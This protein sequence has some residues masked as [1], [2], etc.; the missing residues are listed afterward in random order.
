[1][2]HCRW[3]LL[4][5]IPEEILTGNPDFPPLILQLLY[6]R[7]L[8]EPSRWHSFIAGDESQF[9]DPFLLLGMPAAVNRVYR[10]LLSGE[11]IAIY[12]DFDADGISATALLVQGLSHL[13]YQA[14][15]YIPHRLM[16]GYGLK[17][18]ALEKL[19]QQGI[20]LVIT[21]DCGIT[22]L[23]EIRAA[24][25]MGLDIVVTDHH[26]PLPEIPPAAAIINPRLPGSAYPFRELAG[27]GVALKL[28][29][30]LFQNLGREE[31]LEELM[32]LA[33]LGT[34]ADISPLLGEN[35]YLVKTGL[36]RINNSPRAGIS[37]MINQ[38]RLAPGQVSAENISWTIAPRLNAAGRLEHAMSSYR[39]LMTDSDREAGELAAWL[40]QKNTE[41]QKL[42]S[43]F[44]GRAREQVLAAGISPLLAAGG[45][46]YPLGIS[47]LVAGKLAEEFYRPAIITRVGEKMTTGSCRSIPEFNIIAALSE[48]RHLLSQFGGHSQAA[49]FTLP[50][51]NLS[52]LEDAMRQKA[53]EQ[54]AGADLRRRLDIDIAV[55]LPELGGDTFQNTQILAPF[56]KGNPLPTFLSR[57]VEVNNCRVMGN[58]GEHL[59]L[60]LRQGGSA[61]DGVAFRLGGCIGEISSH[62][63]I[64]YNLEV[65]RWNGAERL[66]L[67][68]LDFAP[69]G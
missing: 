10:A 56:G 52:R 16:E 58:G 20:S 55:S 8:T 21:V 61:W 42:T 22:S 15:P 40:D 14:I 68:I 63:D 47:G 25:R 17:K 11:K 6:N 43:T 45:H 34:I 3:H 9:A 26:S 12:G 2:E 32:D 38:A 44:L 46:D 31:Y 29:Q 1:M 69:S 19:Y 41:R 66:R 5:P 35:R 4:P 30:A 60:T 24:A 49:G 62:L 48:C 13:G 54:L 33:A 28:L 67:N 57:R 64:V 65:D 39:L 27:V 51:R 50:T 18:A 37:E 36:K 53:S 23:D 7:G 59:R